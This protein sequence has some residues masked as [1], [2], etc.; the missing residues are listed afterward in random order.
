MRTKEFDSSKIKIL[1][2]CHKTCDLPKNDIF[3]PIQVGAS[4]SNVDLGMQRD[5]K[6]NGAIC[7]NISN[8][9]KSFCEL[10]A[11]YWAWKNIKKV[12]PELKYIG[13]NHYRRFFAFDKNFFNIYIEKEDRAKDYQLQE[14]KL[15]SLIKKGFSCVA[16]AKIYKY[17]LAT[18]YCVEHISDDYRCLRKIIEDIYPDYTK[19]FDEVMKQNNKL[20][21]FNMFILSWENFDS[22]CNWLFSILFEAEKRIDI[23][24]Y[25]D[26]Q[27]RI[28]GYMAERLFNVW[29]YHNN[30][31]IK[32][33]PIY[34]FADKKMQTKKEYITNNRR[35]NSAFMH[36]LPV[37]LRIKLLL[38]NSL[39]GRKIK[40]LF[41]KGK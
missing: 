15:S 9:N 17:S 22:Y 25:N 21:H 26:V 7:D 6:I 1:V 14:E 30:I 38:N 32:Q 8:K 16:K 29:L 3:L 12:Y 31:K 40:K 18:D 27:K 24:N 4:I 28:F 37:K 13:L 2:C 41:V 23:S 11:M 5:D 33:V 10:T 39:I 19:S 20:F 36:S 34:W 35:C